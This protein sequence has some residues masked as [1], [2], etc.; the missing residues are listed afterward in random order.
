MHPHDR[1]L[2]PPLQAAQRLDNGLGYVRWWR[3]IAVGW[4]GHKVSR[5][6]QADQAAIRAD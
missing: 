4:H 2:K 3:Y 6:P 5:S 1:S